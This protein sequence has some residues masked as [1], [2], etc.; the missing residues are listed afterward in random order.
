MNYNINDIM[1]Y[2]ENYNFL[3]YFTSKEE[4]YLVSS[5]EVGD[6][7]FNF[8]WEDGASKLVIIP[9]N[10]DYVIKIPFN[11]AYNE[12][13]N[14][15]YEYSQNYCETEIELY[16][17]IFQENPLFIQFFLPLTRVEEYREWDVYVQPKCQA[18]NNTDEKIRSK[19]YSKESFTKA[20]KVTQYLSLPTDWVAAVAEILKDISLV[21]EFIDILEEYDITQDL[22]RG[23]I[24]YCNGK[25]V[26]LDYA[27]FYD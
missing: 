12:F 17:K 4:D 19:S 3:E 11:A 1:P 24:G 2:I 10:T 27:G 23:N 8:D 5:I 7:R 25:P 26:I 15:Y 18:Y 13:D 16:D 9:E 14:E 20:K 6:D 22:H 21:E